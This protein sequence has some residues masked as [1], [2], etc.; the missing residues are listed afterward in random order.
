MNDTPK[1]QPA[2][3]EWSVL[4]DPLHTKDNGS[5]ITLN[6]DERE[7]KDLARRFSLLSIDSL[8]AKLVL[9]KIKG[10]N[11]IHVTGSFTAAL[12]QE[13]VVT[14]HP[15]KSLISDEVEGW[16]ADPADIISIKKAR[17]EKA[18]KDGQELQILD[19]EEDPEAFTNGKIDLGEFIAQCLSLAIPPYPRAEGVNFEGHSTAASAE[20]ERA[21]ENPFA[22]L[23]DW[24]GQN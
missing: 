4:F 18:I 19:E 17:H 10:K 5:H 13:C 6:A 8:E 2:L 20:H 15:V 22:A 21:F 24:K 7:R 3:T 12:Q 1:D 23:K 11:A 9:H 14:G 16:F